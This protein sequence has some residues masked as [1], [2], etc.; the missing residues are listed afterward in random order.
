MLKQTVSLCTV[1]DD[2]TVENIE[3]FRAS[4]SVS[5]VSGCV[6]VDGGFETYRIDSDDCKYCYINLV[7]IC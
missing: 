6:S 1:A 7:C 3:E 5:G 4:L 2:T